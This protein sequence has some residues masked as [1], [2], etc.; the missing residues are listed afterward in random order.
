MPLTLADLLGERREAFIDDINREIPTIIRSYEEAGGSLFAVRIG[1]RTLQPAASSDFA[2]AFRACLSSQ[3]ISG[4]S[5]VPDISRAIVSAVT[6]KYKS[7][8]TNHEVALVAA[9]VL[10][11]EILSSKERG[12]ALLSRALRMPPEKVMPIYRLIQPSMKLH[13][14]SRTA[15]HKGSVFARAAAAIPV[16]VGKLGG[17][18]LATISDK[19]VGAVAG[20]IIQAFSEKAIQVSTA[21]AVKDSISK[22]VA[23]A[24]SG[25]IGTSV[26]YIFFGPLALLSGFWLMA[27]LPKKCSE[28]AAENIAKATGQ[29]LK[30]EQQSSETVFTVIEQVLKQIDLEDLGIAGSYLI[31][32]MK[33][34]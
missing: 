16:G 22:S 10:L 25:I 29:S 18:R 15:A 3:E 7:Y 14:E 13:L 17:D 33:Y 24:I 27:A 26:N 12:V 2:K 19:L 11:L 23:E 5:V 31:D 34:S 1:T 9:R 20:I 28:L 30:G 6:A 4:E 32:S 21:N 8:L